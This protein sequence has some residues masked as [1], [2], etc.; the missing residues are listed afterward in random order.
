MSNWLRFVS[1][2]TLIVALGN[3]AVASFFDPLFRITQVRGTVYV[4]RPG[5]EESELVVEGHAYPYGTRVMVRKY[6]PQEEKGKREAV[7]PE[8]HLVLSPDHQ[9]K[10]GPGGEVIV[11]HGDNNDVEKKVIDVI[12]GK[13]RTFITVS[14]ITTGG[15]QDDVVLARISALSVT[16]PLGVTCMDLTERNEIA[17][18]PEGENT[19]VVVLSGGS[20]MRMKGPQFEIPTIKRNSKIEVFGNKDFTRISSLGGEFYASV[21]RGVDRTESVSFKNRSV[22]K[23]WRTYAKIGGRMAVSVMVV[24][25]DNGIRSYAYLEGQTA[26]V[27]TALGSKAKTVESAEAGAE[28]VAATEGEASDTAMDSE[29]FE[30]AGDATEAATD[31]AESN[32]ESMDSSDD[33][34]GSETLDFDPSW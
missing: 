8:A 27:D 33:D 12:S 32:T 14:K 15:S 18:T 16:T 5:A 13:L 26:V 29:G 22:V 24:A 7:V 34:F 6:N 3:S 25:P 9:F 31:F 28:A 2:M 10:V 17:V 21:E 23:I 11:R 20:K 19:T 30:D 4:Q 1:I